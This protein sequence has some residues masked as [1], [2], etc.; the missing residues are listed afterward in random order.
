MAPAFPLS[1]QYNNRLLYDKMRITLSEVENRN[2]TLQKK[3]YSNIFKSH[4]N[5]TK[6][7]YR[8]KSI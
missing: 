6:Y 5:T 1:G 7:N 8:S 2:Y 4:Q 3:V